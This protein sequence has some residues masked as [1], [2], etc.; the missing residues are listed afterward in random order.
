MERELNDSDSRQEPGDSLRQAREAAGLTT[1]EV[2]DSLNLILGNIEAIE[3]NQYEKMNAGLFVRGY[4]KN[5]ARFL[6]LD[7]D[8]LVAAA[9]I[10]L[11]G[12]SRA[13]G[14]ST[15][16]RTGIDGFPEIKPAHKV[17]AALIGAA[18][19]WFGVSALFSGAPAD[20]AGDVNQTPAAA[21]VES[22]E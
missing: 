9:D 10:R 5:Y 18:L 13:D 16:T 3:S 21:G 2:A 8:A 15:Q 14:K 4:V 17:M 1:K 11:K 6:G 20:D 22:G 7:A 12:V 19:I